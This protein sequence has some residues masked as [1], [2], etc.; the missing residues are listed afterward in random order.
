MSAFHIAKHFKYICENL[1]TN[2]IYYYIIFDLLGDMSCVKTL[3][4]SIVYYFTETRKT[5]V[6]I[7]YLGKRVHVIVLSPQKPGGK[8]DGVD[9]CGAVI[10]WTT[11]KSSRKNVIQVGQWDGLSQSSSFHLFIIHQKLCRN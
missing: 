4:S 9:L 3:C 1:L 6:F 5:G 7:Q 10:E 2:V 11:E 8:S